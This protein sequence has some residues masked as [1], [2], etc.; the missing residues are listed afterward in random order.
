[1]SNSSR[2]APRV[3][4]EGIRDASGRAAIREISIESTLV[5]LVFLIAEKQRDEP[6]FMSPSQIPALLGAKTLE[7]TSPYYSHATKLLETIAANASGFVC[8]PVQVPGSQKALLRL[9]IVEYDSSPDGNVE[10]SCW[11]EGELIHCRNTGHYGWTNELISTSNIGMFSLEDPVPYDEFGQAQSTKGQFKRFTG[12]YDWGYYYPIL[13]AEIEFKGEYGNRFGFNIQSVDRKHPA[14][15]FTESP[16]ALYKLSVVENTNGYTPRIVQTVYGENSVVFA[17][18]PCVDQNGK[19]LYLPDVFEEA[20]SLSQGNN[21]LNFG[22]FSRIHVYD[23]YLSSVQDAMWGRL[24][25]FYD[26]DLPAEL[27]SSDW[28]GDQDALE[29]ARFGLINLVD[30]RYSD[31]VTPYRMVKIEK[32]RLIGSMNYAYAQQ[33][34]DGLEKLSNNRARF[35]QANGVLDTFVMDLKAEVE[36]DF[37]YLHNQNRWDYSMVFDSGFATEAKDT[38]IAIGNCRQDVTVMLTPF[39]YGKFEWEDEG[40]VPHCVGA[41]EE[42]LLQ[43]LDYLLWDGNDGRIEVHYDVVINDVVYPWEDTRI[44]TYSR[45][46]EGPY[47]VEDYFYDHPHP[48][49][50]VVESNVMISDQWPTSWKAKTPTNVRV[51]LRPRYETAPNMEEYSNPVHF[52]NNP[53]FH[54]DENG[55]IYFCIKGL[56]EVPED[57]PPP[58]PPPLLF[59][60][61]TLAAYRLGP[62][63]SVIARPGSEGKSLRIEVNGEENYTVNESDST[64]DLG[65]VEVDQVYFP[66]VPSTAAILIRRTWSDSPAPW[67]IKVNFSNDT[68]TDG[69]HGL[70]GVDVSSIELDS[71]ARVQLGIAFENGYYPTTTAP[72]TVDAEEYHFVF[73]NCND[74]T[75]HLDGLLHNETDSNFDF[76]NSV[77]GDWS[78]N[79][80]VF[81]DDNAAAPFSFDLGPRDRPL[82]T[83]VDLSFKGGTTWWDGD[84]WREHENPPALMDAEWIGF[85]VSLDN[86][87]KRLCAVPKP[88]VNGNGV[89]APSALINA[90]WDLINI[91]NTAEGSEV[92]G[93]DNRCPFHLQVNRDSMSEYLTIT[94]HQ[95]DELVRAGLLNDS[96]LIPLDSYLTFYPNDPLLNTLPGP[97][98][99]ISIPEE[100]NWSSLNLRPWRIFTSA[101]FL[102]E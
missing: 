87:P 16:V 35:A 71:F 55:V 101:R 41:T 91:F 61:I 98:Y 28:L 47:R 54:V 89:V 33:G 48:L 15:V 6:V 85:V 50:E 88:S 58:P 97:W 40:Y 10:Q 21:V 9:G 18:Q 95:R 4:H 102:V 24:R 82:S 38:L 34:Q 96:A 52:D 29:R 13:D 8:Y 46:S 69:G 79:P 64:T 44:G 43:E 27:V 7:K 99:D 39:S 53:T 78:Y 30:G 1:M 42:V 83:F 68:Y 73:I 72:M 100:T 56:N 12:E 45:V 84:D 36:S 32:N 23:D 92:I 60:D 26:Q 14:H 11:N 93:T 59:D 81:F 2:G 66:T 51:E 57:P 37:S 62:G 70:A 86:G 74:E 19:S 20:Y 31:G 5:P 22:E 76:Y 80:T 25:A 65:L 49:I 67:D 17:L 77:V 90:M 75:I 3:I 63:D 94:G